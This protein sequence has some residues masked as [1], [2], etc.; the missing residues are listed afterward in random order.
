MWHANFVIIVIVIIIIIIRL[1][2]VKFSRK[3]LI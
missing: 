1:W 3:Q 2:A